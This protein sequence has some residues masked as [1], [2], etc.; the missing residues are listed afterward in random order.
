VKHV[1]TGA[2]DPTKTSVSGKH[3]AGPAQSSGVFSDSESEDSEEE[4]EERRQ[5]CTT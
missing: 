2:G 4:G 1:T 3:P 5:V